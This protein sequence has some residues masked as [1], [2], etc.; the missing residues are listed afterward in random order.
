M[1]KVS[2]GTSDV[3]YF[4]L[5]IPSKVAAEQ[6]IDSTT[7][8]TETNQLSVPIAF[9]IHG[10]YWQSKYAIGCAAIETLAPFFV[11][12]GIATVDVEYRRINVNNNDNIGIYPQPIDDMFESLCKMHEVCISENEDLSKNDGVFLDTKR[13]FIIGH[14]V[15]GYLSLLSCTQLLRPLEDPITQQHQH[16]VLCTRSIPQLPFTPCLCVPLGPVVDLIEARKRMSVYCRYVCI[17]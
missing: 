12:H 17:L 13:I 1:Q 16:P 6:S 15:G 5:Q 2:Y 10:G 8:R 14:S 11:E 9:I 3:H 7:K 4:N